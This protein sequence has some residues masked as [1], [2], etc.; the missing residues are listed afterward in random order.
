[1]ISEASNILLKKKLYV[2]LT[3]ALNIRDIIGNLIHENVKTKDEYEWLKHIRCSYRQD[4][5]FIEYFNYH[6]SYGNE[7]VCMIENPLIQIFSN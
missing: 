5:A 4:Q 3:Q 2:L 6:V 7:F 1:M